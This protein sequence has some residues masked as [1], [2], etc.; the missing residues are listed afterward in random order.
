MTMQWALSGQRSRPMRNGTK[1]G[2]LLQRSFIVVYLTYRN[3]L[4]L[5]FLPIFP[6]ICP[7]FN[8]DDYVDTFL[9]LRDVSAWVRVFFSNSSHLFRHIW[10]FP[11]GW[12]REYPRGH[13]RWQLSGLGARGFILKLNPSSRWHMKLSARTIMQT[14]NPGTTRITFWVRGS[15][16][17]SE[18]FTPFIFLFV[19]VIFDT[20]DHTGTH[21][22]KFSAFWV[23]DE[24]LIGDKYLH[25]TRHI[26]GFRHGRL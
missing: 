23:P 22:S 3:V 4:V 6:S 16:C 2:K 12:P 13:P 21:A 9:R 10:C 1:V 8:T 26:R 25:R 5:C 24:W 17:V 20:D 11:Q 7:V 18:S 15:E 14:S 19:I